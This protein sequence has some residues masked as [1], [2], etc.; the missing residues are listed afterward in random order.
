MTWIR[1]RVE[2]TH[3]NADAGVRFCLLPTVAHWEILLAPQT[4]HCKIEMVIST[5]LGCYEHPK[6]K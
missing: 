5:T 6:K 4:F 2:H 1:P 3:T